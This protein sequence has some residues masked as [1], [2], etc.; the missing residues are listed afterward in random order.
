[1]SDS[2]DNK[3]TLSRRGLFGAVAGAA[4]AVPLIS[5]A[6]QGQGRGAAASAP[7]SPTGTGAPPQS[8]DQGVPTLALIL[9]SGSAL[10]ALF[11]VKTAKVNR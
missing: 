8:P 11:V 3:Q 2:D 1:M 5:D 10:A 6:A 9:L 7:L 4:A